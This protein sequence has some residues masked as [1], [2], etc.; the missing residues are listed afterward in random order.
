MKVWQLIELLDSM[1]QDADVVINTDH[2]TCWAGVPRPDKT[3]G[4]PVVKFSVMGNYYED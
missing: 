2:E 3:N 1:D 4:K